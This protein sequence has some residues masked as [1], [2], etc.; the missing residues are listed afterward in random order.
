MREFFKPL[1]RKFGVLTLVIAC[2]FMALW[3]RSCSVED[4]IYFP[5]RVE[6]FWVAN[7]HAIISYNHSLA[8]L[9]EGCDAVQIGWHWPKLRSKSKVEVVRLDEKYAAQIEEVSFFG[10]GQERES[11]G[12]YFGIRTFVPYWS[13]VLPLTLL[14]AILLLSKP[15]KSIQI[16]IT[17]P[18]PA[19][20]K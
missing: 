2:V 20:G 6:D 7:A 3:V 13:I 12:F 8:W 1:R 15:R 11:L 9:S 10:F 14:S 16:K 19:G 17:E 4:R 5:K 18:I